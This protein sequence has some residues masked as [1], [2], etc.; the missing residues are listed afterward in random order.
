MYSL[1]VNQSGSPRSARRR[2]WTESLG[3]ALMIVA[4]VM[5]IRMMASYAA[6]RAIV[7]YEGTSGTGAIVACGDL[8]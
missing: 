6:A 2:R 3:D 7:F 5:G 4:A 8:T 1:R